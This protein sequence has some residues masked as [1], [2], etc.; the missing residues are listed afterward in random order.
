MNCE[1]AVIFS[2]TCINENMLPLYTNIRFHDRAVQQRE[3]SRE[4]KVQLVHEQLQ[5]KK[6][7]MHSLTDGLQVALSQYEQLNIAV[8]VKNRITQKFDD[9]I[10]DHRDATRTRILKKLCNLY[11][12]S[13]AIPQP[14]IS[15]LN[16]SDLVL[17]EK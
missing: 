14:T 9:I 6:N 8:D 4:F 13:L 17:T 7:A 3:F 15:Y 5:S 16:F 2:T 11:G 10:T 1:H 12:K